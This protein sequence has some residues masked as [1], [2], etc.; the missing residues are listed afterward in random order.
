MH[1]LITLF[2]KSVPS[3]SK[4]TSRFSPNKRTLDYVDVQINLI[5]PSHKKP[6]F[7]YLHKVFRIVQIHEN[8]FLITIR[9]SHEIAC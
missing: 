9:C 7:V 6:L 4:T 5:T 2:L 1:R 3:N 8:V